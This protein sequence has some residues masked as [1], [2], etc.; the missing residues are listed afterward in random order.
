MKQL[1]DDN[2]LSPKA[3]EDYPDLLGLISRG[4]RSTNRQ[5]ASIIPNTPSLSK[6]GV[7]IPV[8]YE[9]IGCFRFSEGLA[10]VNLNDK[11]GFIDKTGNEVIP[12]K[13]DSAGS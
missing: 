4:D 10:A 8:I 6:Y 12:I 2:G 3:T 11:S 13:Y 7:I 9:N 1:E 5:N